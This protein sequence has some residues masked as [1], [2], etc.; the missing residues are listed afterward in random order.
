MEKPHISTIA[1]CSCVVKWMRKYRW[2]SSGTTFGLSNTPG[3][4]FL[5]A[6]ESLLLKMAKIRATVLLSLFNR[7]GLGLREHHWR[8]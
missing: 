4:A 7:D 2:V 8:P 1:L 6:V 3:Q 5:M